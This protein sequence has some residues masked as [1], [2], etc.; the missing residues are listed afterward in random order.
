MKKKLFSP[1]T[2]TIG[3]LCL[4]CAAVLVGVLYWKSAPETNF[5]PEA[6]TSIGVSDTWEDNGSSLPAGG[7]TQKPT[8]DQTP[9][10]ETGKPADDNYKVASESESEVVI[11]MTPPVEKPKAPDVPA[12]KSP[13][14]DNTVPEQ[15]ASEGECIPSTPEKKPETSQPGR[16]NDP[17]FGWTE[18]P[19][20]QGETVDNDK[21]PNKIVGS[22]G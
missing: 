21:D 13:N 19:P 5:T 11:N 3:C 12:D 22:M 6:D 10:A 8:G 2:L 15:P 14:S 1:K 4:L 18:V 7:N 9:G 16:V 17:V 20:A